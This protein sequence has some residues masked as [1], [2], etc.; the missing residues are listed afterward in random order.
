MIQDQLMT[1][2]WIKRNKTDFQ[3]SMY[4]N[5]VGNAAFQISG[6]VKYFHLAVR[7]PLC[8][9]I[10]LQ[11][12]LLFSLNFP[13]LPCVIEKGCFSISRETLGYSDYFEHLMKSWLMRQK[14]KVSG[15]FRIFHCCLVMVPGMCGPQQQHQPADGQGRDKPERQSHHTENSRIQSGSSSAVLPSNQP[16]HCFTS[17]LFVM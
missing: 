5:C 14:D 7:Q 15:L 2:R 4:R 12:K 16:W 10:S 3:N 9:H 6:F 17:V 1:Y 13:W 8:V 11:A